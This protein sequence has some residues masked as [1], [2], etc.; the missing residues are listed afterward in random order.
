MPVATDSF[1]RVPAPASSVVNADY[2]ADTV[3]DDIKIKFIQKDVIFVD[4]LDAGPQV[5]TGLSREEA[6]GLGMLTLVKTASGKFNLE[7]MLPVTLARTRASKP[8]QPLRSW[9]PHQPVLQS[10]RQHHQKS[11]ASSS[12]E[13]TPAALPLLPATGEGSHDSHGSQSSVVSDAEVESV[14]KPPDITSSD[15]RRF[16]QPIEGAPYPGD[17]NVKV[18]GR[19]DPSSSIIV[20]FELRLASGTTFGKLL[21]ALSHRKMQPFCFRKIGFAYLGCRDFMCILFCHLL[22]RPSPDFLRPFSSSFALFGVLPAPRPLLYDF[23]TAYWSQPRP[24][25]DVPRHCVVMGL[26]GKNTAKN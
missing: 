22:S 9:L 10:R 14:G 11:T 20:I 16:Q 4:V 26:P 8:V 17:F 24:P 25:N 3:P 6:T 19:L 23:P 15:G 2:T 13:G 1:L 18:R 21:D 5:G 12:D 7:W